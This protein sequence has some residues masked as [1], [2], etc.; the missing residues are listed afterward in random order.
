MQT[1]A[2]YVVA[3]V[4]TAGILVLPA[5][6]FSMLYSIL[7]FPNF[8]IGAYLTL[9]AYAAFAVNR[10]LRWGL[11]PSFAV[12][13]AAS[14]LVALVVDRLAFRPMRRARPLALLV[15]SIGV[16][17]VLENVPRLVW[18][19]DLQSY[20]VPVRRPWV[21]GPVR[22]NADQLWI[23]GSPSPSW[24]WSIFCSATPRSA[25]RCGPPPTTRTSPASGGLTPRA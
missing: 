11:G 22:I 17:F 21:L 24:S 13:L 8:A 10:G 20:D 15:N 14:A 16:A 23:I 6:T 25:R 7:R 19:N 1:L 18:G 2:P 5:V 9:G 3:G 12:A 4:V